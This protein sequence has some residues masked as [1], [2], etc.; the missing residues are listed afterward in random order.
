[1]TASFIRTV[2]YSTQVSGRLLVKC[3]NHQS[4]TGRMLKIGH[5]VCAQM[6][7]ANRK[8][9]KANRTAV[10]FVRIFIQY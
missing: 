8:K 1:M 3:V 2:F 9:T 6:A 10:S 4:R 5:I 7:K